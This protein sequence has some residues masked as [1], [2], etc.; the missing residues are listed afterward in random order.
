[1]TMPDARLADFLANPRETREVELKQWLDLSDPVKRAKVGRHLMALANRGGGWLQFGFVEQ[2]DGTFVHEGIACPNVTAYSTDAINA[3]VARHAHPRFHCEVFWET[4][5]ESCPGPHALIRVPG[6]H[7]VPVVCARSG[8]DPGN[9]PRKG[10]VYDRLPGPES[11]PITEA[12]DWHDLLDRCMRERRDELVASVTAAIELLG[13][14]GLASALAG[15]SGTAT[16]VAGAPTEPEED[17]ARRLEALTN[18]TDACSARLAERLGEPGEDPGLYE[19]GSWSFS[20]AVDPPPAPPVSLGELR[21]ILLEVVGTETGWPAWWWP[22]RDDAS[23]PRVIG[24]AIECWMRGGVFPDASHADFWRAS[25]EGELFLL[26][27]YDEDSAAERSQS[28]LHVAPGSLLDPGIVVWRVGECLLHAQR[29]ARRLAAPA[30]EIEVRWNELEG[31]EIGTLEPMLR[32]YHAGPC[33]E[34]EVRSTMRVASDVISGAL[35]DLVRQLTTPLFVLFDFF[36][37]PLEDI[38]REMERMRG[39]TGEG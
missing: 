27:G 4:C 33:H 10:A 35:P 9:D 11:A 19:A 32:R 18:W 1:M 29:L 22:S 28:H 39:R 16:V 14:D 13:A 25:G 31:R 8:P 24:K 6:G 12:N 3:I 7:R 5:E 17:P 38:A 23:S 36:E 34:R 26:R 15:P 20:Y 2:N 30:V 37:M 21:G